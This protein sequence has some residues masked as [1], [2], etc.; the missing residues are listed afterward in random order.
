[1]EVE[2]VIESLLNGFDNNILVDIVDVWVEVAEIKN[3]DA[4]YLNLQS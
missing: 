4:K 3:T 1:M 2:D